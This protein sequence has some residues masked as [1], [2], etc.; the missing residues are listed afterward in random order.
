MTIRPNDLMAAALAIT[1]R[2]RYWQ[3]TL[4]GAP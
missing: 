1:G 3:G 2:V 4:P